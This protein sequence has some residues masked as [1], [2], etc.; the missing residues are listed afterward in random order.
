MGFLGT[1]STNCFLFLK[2]NP[3]KQHTLTIYEVLAV[4]PEMGKGTGLVVPVFSA[5]QC[6][7]E[8][9]KEGEPG[10][11][12]SKILMFSSERHQY[13]LL[14][15]GRE[16]NVLDSR[17]GEAWVNISIIAFLLGSCV[18]AK[19]ASAPLSKAGSTSTHNLP[20]WPDQNIFN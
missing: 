19:W 4:F 17:E 2:V 14:R 15:L 1:L 9:A 7:V 20:M 8:W 10:R 12:E 16:E 13:H 5:G 18:K 11:G 3:N 6:N